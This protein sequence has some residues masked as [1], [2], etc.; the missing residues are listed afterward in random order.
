MRHDILSDVLNIIKT[1]ERMGKKECTVPAQGTVKD[2]LAVMQRRKYIGT[3]EFIDDGKSGNFKIY[4]LGKINGC[5]TIKPRFAVA[6]DEFTKYEKRFL[7]ASNI[8]LLILSTPH[9]V[10]DHMEARKKKT[11]G[12]LLCY[13]W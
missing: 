12:K 9:G 3:F 4:L 5:G 10:M 13:V 6:E 2:I 11:G 7:P 8:G 1:S